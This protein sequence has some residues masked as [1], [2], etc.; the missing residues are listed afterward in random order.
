MKKLGFLFIFICFLPLCLVGCEQEKQLNSYIIDAV[1]DEQNHSLSCQQTVTYVNNSNNVL[2]ELCFFLYANSFEEGKRVVPTSYEN[3]AYPNGESFG[4]IDMK[5][6]KINGTDSDFLVSDAKNILTIMLEKELFPN[7]S[8]VV[9]LEYVVDLANINHRLGYGNNA[10][11]F[12]SFFPIVCVYEDGRGFVKNDFSSSGDPFY[13]DIA[14]FEVNITYPNEFVIASTGEQIESE[15]K[16]N[17]IV[18]KY[19]AE[20]VR[21]FCFVLSAKFEMLKEMVGDTEVRYYFY[22]DENAQE[23]LQTATNAL[24]TFEELFGDYPYSQLS[25]VK[26][27]FC[28]GG[29]EYPNLVMI[30]DDL[31]SS[32]T[33]N[34]VIV[35]EIAH[36]WWYGMVGNNE[37]EDSWIDEGLTEFSTALFFERH[38]EYGL[39]YDQIMDNALQ[40]YKNFAKIYSDIL[41]SVDESMNRNLNEFDTEPEY[42]NCVYTKGMLLFNQVRQSMNDKKFF[43]CLRD[44]FKT[45]KFQNSSPEKLIESFCKSTH[46]NLES[47]FDAWIN[48]KVV[49]Q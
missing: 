3:R 13:S 30:S 16:D 23:H 2:D 49:F 37:F 29:M 39:D 1:Y 17:Q 42:V 12:G 47:F 32:E 10:V 6:I 26:T 28:F 41:G 9:D 24:A 31:D 40:T 7:E 15:K 20:N 44:Y 33:D 5:C 36:Q 11:N 34:Y 22:D 21:D 14:N 35:H 48:G 19:R 25:V 45:Y 8:V 18:A 38:Q 4:S 27:N 46:T 43:A